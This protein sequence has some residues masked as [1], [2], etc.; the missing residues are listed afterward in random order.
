MDHPYNTRSKKRSRP[1]SPP[2]P[3]PPAEDDFNQIVNHLRFI[4][5]THI[6]TDLY[7]LEIT[8]NKHKVLKYLKKLKKALKSRTTKE[9]LNDELVYAAGQLSSDIAFEVIT[10]LE[11]GVKKSQH[12][13]LYINEMIKNLE[14]IDEVGDIDGV[15]QEEETASDVDEH[16]NIKDLIDYSVPDEWHQQFSS[17]QELCQDHNPHKRQKRIRIKISDLDSDSDHKDTESDS[18]ESEDEFD[19][20]EDSDITSEGEDEGK[21]ESDS[22][23]I[24]DSLDSYESDSSSRSVVGGLLQ[25]ADHHGVTEQ[26]LLDSLDWKFIYSK[27]KKKTNQS[28]RDVAYF[29]NLSHEKKHDMLSQIDKVN[30][31]NKEE[32]PLTFRALLSKMPI[33]AKAELMRKMETLGGDENNY[34]LKEWAVNILKLPLGVYKKQDTSMTPEENL[35]KCQ[36]F[37]DQAVFGHEKAKQKILQILAQRISNPDDQSG[38]VLGI[39]GPMGNG[40]TT[41]VEKGISKALDIPFTYIPLGGA[42]DSSFLEGHSYTY[43]GSQPG[44]IVNILNQAKC[45]NPIIFFD[46]LDKV[47]TTPHGQEIT[48]VL[49]HLTDPVQNH[50]FQDRYF[51]GVDLDLSK[52]TLIFSYNDIENLNPILRDRITEIQTKGFK[53]KEKISIVRHS[54]WNSITKTVNQ[55]NIT[56]SD[57][58]L[59]H[60]MDHY[61]Y[62]GGVRQLKKLL[63]DLVQEVN[64]RMLQSSGTIGDRNIKNQDS[65]E[66]TIDLIEKDLFLDKPKITPEKIPDK[67]CVGR[68]NG[69]FAMCNDMGGIMSIETRLIPMSQM[70]DLQLTGQQGSVLKE[71]T[72]VAKS[73][74]WSY[75]PDRKKKALLKE[76]KEHPLGF[77]IH[78]PEGATP[79]DGPSAG[80][81]ITITILSV[82]LNNPIKRDIAITGEIN[83]YGEVM[84]IGGLLHKCYGAYKEGVKTIFYPKDNEKDMLQIKKEYPELWEDPSFTTIAVGHVSEV[85]PHVYLN[86][87]KLNLDKD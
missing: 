7:D 3:T 73:V 64:L 58:T 48:N 69:L 60:L 70:M 57:D 55:P 67:S 65:V 28:S 6:K 86:P 8:E 33:E 36:T 38:L 1:S 34:K 43:E 46:E 85:I 29:R 20:S 54:L 44:K 19:D 24:S 27:A 62:E 21:S 39:Q 16:G 81:A 11:N 63:E 42:T 61:T 4:I 71:S 25:W 23:E 56:I 59:L 26:H 31:I 45:M 80:T 52:A 72:K 40:K 9:S 82:L 5:L 22:S 37:L 18:Q 51:T 12:P 75:V 68:I 76:W 74:A 2:P 79:K 17:L 66:I 87:V 78:C 10:Q 53:N 47:S 30:K 13:I 50:H 77:H 32:I 49:M 35:R 83:L 15:D 14:D 84:K 41:L